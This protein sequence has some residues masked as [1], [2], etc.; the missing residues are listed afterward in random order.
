MEHQVTIRN[1]KFQIEDKPM[2]K[3]QAIKTEHNL[4]IQNRTF[5]KTEHEVV[6]HKETFEMSTKCQFVSVNLKWHMKCQFKM[7]QLNQ[8]SDLKR[9]MS[10]T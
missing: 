10:N 8:I 1:R 2:I 5:G 4:T 7:E 6:I 9:N 3:N